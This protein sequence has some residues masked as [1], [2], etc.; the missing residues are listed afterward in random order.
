MYRKELASIRKFGFVDPVIVRERDSWYEIVDGEHRWRA[1]KELGYTEIP[2]YSIGD[3]SDA[4]AK[5]LTIVLNETRGRSDSKRLGAVLKDLLESVP[6]TDLLDLLPYSPPVFDRLTGLDSLEEWD[7]PSQL[8]AG[9]WVERTYRL[10]KDAAEV[11]DE[12][13]AKARN[14]EEMADWQALEFLAAEF[15]GG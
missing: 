13:L 10:P 1:A 15:L 7:A 2:I 3:V 9:G 8:P 12:A 11:L 6:K 4:D 14:G 5:Q